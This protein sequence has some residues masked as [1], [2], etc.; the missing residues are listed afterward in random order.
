[1]LCGVSVRF[2]PPS[3][4][5]CQDHRDGAV[6]LL[7]TK[8]VLVYCLLSSACASCFVVMSASVDLALNWG[9]R[10][11]RAALSAHIT[12]AGPFFIFMQGEA[13]PPLS[14]VPLLL[15]LLLLF[16]L[17]LSFSFFFSFSV[18]SDFFVILLLG[19]WNIHVI[20]LLFLLSRA[21]SAGTDGNNATSTSS[22]SSG[23]VKA[24][25]YSNQRDSSDA[26]AD[27]DADATPT[28]TTQQLSSDNN[29][30][31]SCYEDD[32]QLHQQ[33][34]EESIHL[35]EMP[36]QQQQQQL[37]QQPHFYYYEDCL[38][39]EEE[40]QEEEE[41]D[42]DD[43]DDDDDEIEGYESSLGPLASSPESTKYYYYR[44]YSR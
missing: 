16:L 35:W 18:K 12:S 44:T 7:R 21:P 34:R 38:R 32:E 4:S 39:E 41:Q 2:P 24:V 11:A 30:S 9:P 37:Q 6:A 5:R 8:A 17:F 23:Y 1:M 29:N 28:T 31:C 26:D 10:A 42:D 25:C 27:A 15:L 3:S 19:L 14:P 20:S 13:P 36:Q 33:L 22:S 43:D 40:E